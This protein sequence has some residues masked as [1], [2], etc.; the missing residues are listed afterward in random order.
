ME[1]PA[2]TWQFNSSPRGSDAFFRL[3]WALDTDLVH[4]HAHRQNIHINLKKLH[5]FKNVTVAG[6]NETVNDI[7]RVL[8]IP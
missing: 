5:Y 4:R 1:F 7:Y 8:T 3:L 6:G 2:L